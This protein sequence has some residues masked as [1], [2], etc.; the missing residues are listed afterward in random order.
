MILLEAL[1]LYCERTEPGL[2]SEP[3]N[4]LTNF[5][6]LFA[7][8]MLWQRQ[9]PSEARREARRMAVLLAV[10]GVGSGLFHLT[11]QQW[12]NWA[13]VGAIMLFIV[14]FLQRYLSR[15]V[16]ASSG[17][18]VLAVIG[19]LL[20]CRLIGSFGDLGMNGSEPYLAPWLVL[21]IFSRWAARKSPASLPW[22]LAAS[23]LFPISLALRSLDLALCDAWPMGTHFG[24]HLLNAMVLYLCARGLAAGCHERSGCYHGLLT[25]DTV[26]ERSNR[27]RR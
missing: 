1:D 27:G 21:A 26:V 14:V 15:V 9:L 25:S 11:G 22:M 17:G 24:W 20:L 5:A 7:A 12:A 16:R 18:V 8:W 4:V 23:C 3:F 10:V 6:F 2:W 19:L 13:D